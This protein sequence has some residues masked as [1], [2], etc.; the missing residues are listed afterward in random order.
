MNKEI[1]SIQD[2]L[3]MYEKK[4]QSVILND[5]KVVRFIKEKRNIFPTAKSEQR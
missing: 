5:G 2:C 3:D 1:I 4:G